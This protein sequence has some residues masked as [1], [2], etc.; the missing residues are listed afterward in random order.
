METTL[1]LKRSG[2]LEGGRL[3]A[4]KLHFL[5]RGLFGRLGERREEHVA[6][7]GRRHNTQEAHKP[8]LPVCKPQKACRQGR[9][10]ISQRLVPCLHLLA[11]WAIISMCWAEISVHKY[12]KAL[13]ITLTRHQSRAVL[14]HSNGHAAQVAAARI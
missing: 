9:L 3:E 8:W 13:D 12:P 4:L 10:H 11:S 14:A 6:V 5:A 7:N 1:L 2:K